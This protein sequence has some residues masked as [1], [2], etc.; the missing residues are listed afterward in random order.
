VRGVRRGG[1]Y[2]QMHAK[3]VVTPTVASEVAATQ[4]QSQSQ[5]L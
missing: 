2:E 3:V 4:T 1:G 5:S